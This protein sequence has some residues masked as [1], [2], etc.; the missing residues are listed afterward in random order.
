MGKSHDYASSWRWA[1][2]WFALMML[3]KSSVYWALSQL[4]RGGNGAGAAAVSLVW[5]SCSLAFFWC[6]VQGLY[7]LA[8]ASDGASASPGPRA[9]GVRRL[10]SSS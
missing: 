8:A 10:S 1:G 7:R 9:D 2:A 5:V 6:L 4:G 3:G